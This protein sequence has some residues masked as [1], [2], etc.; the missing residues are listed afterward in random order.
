MIE[1]IRFLLLF[2]T[3]TAKN[4]LEHVNW[5]SELSFNETV[6]QRAI[7][8]NLFEVSFGFFPLLFR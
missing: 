7:N 1:A 2:T 8:N 3:L 5:L 4:L 6:V